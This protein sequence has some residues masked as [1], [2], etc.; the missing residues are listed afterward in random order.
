MY[1][2]PE[3]DFTYPALSLI[4][5]FHD[6][7][8]LNYAMGL[9]LHLWLVLQLRNSNK[10]VIFIDFFKSSQCLPNA[11]EFYTSYQVVN[12]VIGENS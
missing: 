6:P 2:Q 10:I 5:Y 9:L 4:A 11:V 3:F 12:V 8:F 1:L 7:P